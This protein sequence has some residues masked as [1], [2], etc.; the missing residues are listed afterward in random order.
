MTEVVAV[1][2]ISAGSSLLGATVGAVTTYRVSR[3]GSE[4]A[5]ATAGAQKEVELA[6]IEAE[7]SRLREQHSEDERRN[8]QATYHRALT[9]LQRVYGLEPDSPD[10]DEVQA[11]WRYCRSGVKIFG[12]PTVTQTVEEVQLV[13]RRFPGED[14][15]EKWQQELSDGM[16]KFVAAVRADIGVQEPDSQSNR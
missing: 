5:I 1:A 7:N 12:A 14:D 2:L 3:R 9:V 11:E 10:L 8:R 16:N 6:K 13:V 4:T 15:R